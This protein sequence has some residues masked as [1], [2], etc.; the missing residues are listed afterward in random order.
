MHRVLL[1]VPGVA[2][3]ACLACR[4]HRIMVAAY[5]RDGDEGRTPPLSGI[6]FACTGTPSVVSIDVVKV[7]KT[8]VEPKRL[9]V[10]S[11]RS[12]GSR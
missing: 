10:E 6:E 5:Y 2:F 3:S 1:S 7:E 11:E 4:A 8:V 12:R 9:I